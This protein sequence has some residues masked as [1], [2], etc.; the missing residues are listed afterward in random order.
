[1]MSLAPL[2]RTPHALAPMHALLAESRSTHPLLDMARYARD[3]ENGFLRFPRDYETGA[4][5][6]C[7]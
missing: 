4:D 1:M 7:R 6:A 2:F 3:L 5:A